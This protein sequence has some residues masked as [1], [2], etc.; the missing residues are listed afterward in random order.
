MAPQGGL[1]QF[2]EAPYDGWRARHPQEFTLYGLAPC[3]NHDNYIS[4][5]PTR[6]P[7]KE[8]LQP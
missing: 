6:R 8:G 4:R 7:T 5:C 1:P 3:T 2:G